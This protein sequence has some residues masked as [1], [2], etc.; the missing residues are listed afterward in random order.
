MGNIFN[1]S[2]QGTDLAHHWPY[3]DL[4]VYYKTTTSKFDSW[5]NRKMQHTTARIKNRFV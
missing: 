5:T 2:T 3:K 1:T 4:N